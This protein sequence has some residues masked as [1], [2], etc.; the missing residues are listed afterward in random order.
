VTRKASDSPNL[1]THLS[2]PPR[3]SM[4]DALIPVIRPI[5][6]SRRPMSMLLNGRPYAPNDMLPSERIPLDSI[7][8]LEFST[9]MKWAVSKSRRSG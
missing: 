4:R 9:L 7:Q 6:I 3:Y 1:P 5:G 8:L 2:K